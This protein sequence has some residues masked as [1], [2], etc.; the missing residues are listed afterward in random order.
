[1]FELL[2]ILN[3]PL[4][5][6][7]VLLGIKSFKIS[8]CLLSCSTIQENVSI[9]FDGSKLLSGG[10]LDSTELSYAFH[11]DGDY[12][13]GIHSSLRLALFLD[14]LLFLFDW[15]LL[16]LIFW[17]GGCRLSLDDKLRPIF[18]EVDESV[19][20]HRLVQFVDDLLLILI[21]GSEEV[22]IRE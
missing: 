7:L 18:M 21:L 4:V 11:Q 3:L 13:F 12:W 1:M 6:P 9:P 19:P 15:R 22:Y 20:T 8:I 17:L 14:R 5:G 10:R 2:L 16:S